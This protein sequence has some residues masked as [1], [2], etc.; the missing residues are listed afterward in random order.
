[1]AYI[2]TSIPGDHEFNEFKKKFK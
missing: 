1:M 2:I